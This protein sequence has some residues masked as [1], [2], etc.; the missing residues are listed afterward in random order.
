MNNQH[1]NPGTTNPADQSYPA[2]GISSPPAAPGPR[3]A[4]G[5]SCGELQLPAI[6][7]TRALPVA[8]LGLAAEVR[9]ADA[10]QVCQIE[11]TVVE[12][13]PPTREVDTVQRRPGGLPKN[14][15]IR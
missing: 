10:S 13:R 3:A 7:P 2:A 1:I 4:N 14:V 5:A 11:V 12:T 9:A 6:G 8:G 15:M